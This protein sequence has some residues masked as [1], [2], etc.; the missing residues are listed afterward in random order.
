MNATPGMK[1][2]HTP[3]AGPGRQALRRSYRAIRLLAL[4]GILATLA[5]QIWGS[6][7]N[8]A[9]LPLRWHAAEILAAVV[10]IA[11]AYQ[12]L[13]LAWLL[14][15]RKPTPADPSESTLAG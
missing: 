13:F 2:S 7:V 4:G 11:L 12:L 10:A 14:E 9:G 3:E 5:W 6:R 15:R 1:A 8:L